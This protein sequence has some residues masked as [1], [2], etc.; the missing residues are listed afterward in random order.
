MQARVFEHVT[1]A[2]SE[3]RRKC[4][5]DDMDPFPSTP[6]GEV[7]PSA[8]STFSED[9]EAAP[10]DNGRPATADEAADGTWTSFDTAAM[11]TVTVDSQDVAFVLTESGDALAADS[12]GDGVSTQRDENDSK[13]EMNGPEPEPA[14][15]AAFHYD[16][17]AAAAT[18]H[19][20]EPAA[21]NSS[22]DINDDEVRKA[23]IFLNN[24]AFCCFFNPSLTEVYEFC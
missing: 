10:A 2:T 3:R 21:S 22:H 7:P 20:E 16:D 13:E 15:A 18:S 17:P 9:P 1:T 5:F 23:C 4:V 11:T 8:C 6:F 14:A 19:D 24:S 12:I